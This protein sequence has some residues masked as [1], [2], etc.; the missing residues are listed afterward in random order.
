M[1]NWWSSLSMDPTFE[2]VHCNVPPFVWLQGLSILV[3]SGCRCEADSSPETSPKDTQ[4]S[5]H[6]NVCLLKCVSKVSNVM[7][8]GVYTLLWIRVYECT[9]SQIRSHFFSLSY[10]RRSRALSGGKF[11]EFWKYKNVNISFISNHSFPFFLLIWLFIAAVTE[12]A[13][14]TD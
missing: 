12:C 2:K 11:I 7:M 4:Q 10:C 8:A 6:C 3:A 9:W 5:R 14:A 1:L 13:S